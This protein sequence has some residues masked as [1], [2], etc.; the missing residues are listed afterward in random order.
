MPAKKTMARSI[1]LKQIL[2]ALLLFA[3]TTR[4]FAQETPPAPSE[5]V[6]IVEIKRIVKQKGL[7]YPVTVTGF[8]VDGKRQGEIKFQ[9]PDGR[10]MRSE[11]Y[12]DD[13]LHGVVTNFY[14]NGEK[15]STESYVHGVEHGDWRIWTEKGKLLVRLSKIHGEL[16][17]R[18]EHYYVNGKV[19]SISRFHGH[20]NHGRL[21]EY[22][23]NGVRSLS[24]RHNMGEVENIT[25]G[26]ERDAADEH[27]DQLRM[28]EQQK[29]FLAY[30][31]PLEFSVEATEEVKDESTEY[32][33]T[34]ALEEI[35]VQASD[36]N[37]ISGRVEKRILPRSGF[38][39]VRMFTE[40]GRLVS[41][42]ATH[43]GVQHGPCVIY[44][45][46]GKL[47]SFIEYS[48]GVTHGV[49]NIF[50]SQGKPLS[51]GSYSEGLQYGLE[52]DYYSTGERSAWRAVC[53]GELQGNLQRFNRSGEL[54]YIKDYE[55]GRLQGTSE[56]AALS[57]EE[58]VDVE[59]QE[60]LL[61]Q[62]I[63]ELWK[64]ER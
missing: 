50:D 12:L 45:P 31:M 61:N 1:E 7:N 54:V 13:R 3:L 23:Y 5:K 36:A 26:A 19:A 46:N 11:P 35:P 32:E 44:R 41:E 29:D 2:A 49:A 24:A 22:K 39:M 8:L 59:R 64:M 37:P 52:T 9:A 60:D 25:P 4:S 14:P 51:S 28:S 30:W 47:Y 53:A 63:M 17:G 43:N 6:A 21:E 10:I 20:K 34:F 55:D 27:Q 38:G 40:D 56:F 18:Q 15:R 16:H 42:I 57:K 58:K 33:E 48:L 62:N